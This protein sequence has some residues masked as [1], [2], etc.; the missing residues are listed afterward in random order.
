MLHFSIRS[1]QSM[2]RPDQNYAFNKFHTKFEEEKKY[3]NLKYL[4]KFSLNPGIKVQTIIFLISY[5]T[6]LG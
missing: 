6:M 2:L 4:L 3:I 1:E 5:L